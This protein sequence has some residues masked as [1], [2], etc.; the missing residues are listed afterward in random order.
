M[1]GQ[2]YTITFGDQAE[3]HVG[4]QKLGALAPEGFTLQDLQQAEAWF[5]QHGATPT[6]YNL[7][8]QLPIELHSQT[9]D[10][11]LLHVPAGVDCIVSANNLLQEQRQL[12][13]DTQAVM[14]GRVVNKRARYNLCF[15]EQSQEPDYDAGKGRVVAF[16]QVEHLQQLR[17]TLPEI[18]GVKAANLLAEGNYYYDITKTG[19]GFHGDAERRKVIAIRLGAPLPLQYQWFYQSNS[20][21]TRGGLMLNHGDLYIMSEKAVGTDW[22]KR[23]QLTLRHA[24]G[25][26]KYLQTKR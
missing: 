17:Q 13:Y 26:S 12:H 2:T 24:A 7:K 14:Y 18:I 21:G 16:D 25:A 6:I 22:K 9:E 23:S 20:V 10:A 5:K 4:M 8:L 1:E 3:N 19:I 11:Y 15:A